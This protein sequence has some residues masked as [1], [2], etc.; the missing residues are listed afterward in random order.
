MSKN[1]T[2]FGPFTLDPD[3]GTLLRQGEPVALGRRG[4][5]LLH[6][7]LARP[8]EILTK[9]ELMD[10]GWHG[11]VVEESNLSV[12]VALLRKA[13]GPSP[14]GGEW[15][16]TVPRIGYRFL[17]PS[18]EQEAKVAVQQAKPSLAV[19]PLTSL[20][21]DT[22]QE[23]FADGL[24]EEIITM[25]SKLSGLVVIARS[26]SFA[27]KGKS[28]DIRTIASD[29]GVRFVLAGSVRRSGNRLR[30]VA[31]L[32]DGE[33][34]VHQWAE[35]YDRELADMIAV[36]E[37]VARQ[38]V[39]EL[40]IALS[41][42]EVTQWPRMASTGT[43]DIAAY[44][45]FLRGRAM[46]RGATQNGDVFKRTSELFR[47]AIKQDPGYPAP[48]AALAMAMAHAYYNRWTDDP[49][50]ALTEA[51]KLVEEAIERDPNDAFP[52]GVAALISMYRKDFERWESEVEISLAL[53]PNFAPSLSLRGTLNMYSGKPLTAIEDLERA[54][55]L[56]PLFSHLYLHHLGV[57]HL[58]AG[59]Y[60]TAAALLRERILLV[61]ET[62][63]SRAYLAA[64]LG[65]LG[66]RQGAWQVWQELKAIK[67]DYS[68]T[69]GIGQAPFRDPAGLE[70]VRC[71]LL[72]AGLDLE[73]A[74][75]ADGL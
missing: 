10:A 35:S 5:L 3:K 33:T 27:Y 26:S 6:A 32:S 24:A 51:G 31:Q 53:N 25:L 62:D 41:P 38:I 44:D 61:P 12:Q 56:D 74:T 29:L 15:I 8:G 20:S 47:Q 68:F 73:P 49:D 14:D 37:E 16:A 69:K 75:D 52:H 50:C 43:K 22:E 39:G 57:A 9:T 19:L 63:M 45:C 17:R 58:I 42:R 18:L 59:K 54:M 66:D 21:T 55:R 64:T 4:I 1:A 72:A 23:Y 34:G 7:L 46:Q 36:Q 30:I 11:N 71:G 40:H 13:L 67:P 2:V 65:L 70:R 28:V 48:Y 60:Q